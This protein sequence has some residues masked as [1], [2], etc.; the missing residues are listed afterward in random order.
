VDQHLEQPP[1]LDESRWAAIREHED[2]LKAAAAIQDKRLIIGSAKELMESVA[3]A[4]IEAKNFVVPSNADF[5]EVIRAAHQAIDRQAGAGLDMGPEIRTVAASSRKIAVAVRD[6]RNEYGTGHGRASVAEMEEELATVTV[7]ACYLWSGWALRRLGHVLANEPQRLIDTL[8]NDIVTRASLRTQ[9]EAIRMPQ[10]PAPVQRALG[11][12][13]AQRW[14]SNDTFVAREVGIDP[15]VYNTS[16]SDFPVPYREGLAEGLVLDR[17]GHL[18]LTKATLPSLAG[19]LQPI[20]TPDLES[21]LRELAA[22]VKAA[23]VAAQ[24]LV[25]DLAELAREAS[26]EAARFQLTAQPGW[27]QFVESL[28]RGER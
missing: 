28:R 21:F 3:R 22:K 20:P 10:Q 18:Q 12:A 24:R 16:L 15:A 9:F 17:G 8:Q 6:I 26:L 4:I 11:A 5:D 25:T 13:F 23:G 2:R 14:A 19:V 27:R 7:D 1:H